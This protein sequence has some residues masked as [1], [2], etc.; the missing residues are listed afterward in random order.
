MQPLFRIR[1]M[2]APGFVS[3]AIRRATF[4]EFSHVEIETDRG[5]FIGAHSSGGV[6]E[7]PGD[8]SK[9]SFERRYAIPVTPEQHGLIMAFA[10]G[11]IGTAYNFEDIAGLLIHDNMTS[12]DRLICSQFVF[13]AALAGGIQ[14]LNVLPG[15]SNLVTPETLHLSPLLIGRCYLQTEVPA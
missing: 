1:F 11:K 12:P 14:L 7:R 2:T 13:Q 10:E 15:Y 3:W 4:S 9:P 6:Q 8:Y 5:T